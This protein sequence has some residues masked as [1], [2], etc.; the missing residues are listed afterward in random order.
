MTLRIR[1]VLLAGTAVVTPFLASSALAQEAENT[2]PGE[3]IVTAQR[4]SESLQKV[5]IQVSALTEQ[6]VA[7]AGIKSTGDAIAQVANVTFDKG[8]NFR[9]S[10]ITMRGLTQINN[11]DPPIAFVVDGVPQTTSETIGVSL[12]DVERIEILKGPQG[13]LYGRNA[14]GGAINLV[15]KEPTN[16]FEGFGNLTYASGNSWDVAGGASGALIKDA[17]MFRVAGTYKHASGQIENT[18]RNDKSD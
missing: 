6:K 2:E 13:A 15:T 12:F 16:N 14:V 10:F 3:I 17:L 9:S 5:P 8:N 1:R 18:F 11:A 4:R 7:D